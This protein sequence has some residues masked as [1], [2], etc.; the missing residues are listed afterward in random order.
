MNIHISM[1]NLLY[2]PSHIQDSMY[3]G[4]CYPKCGAPGATR[5]SKC[6]YFNYRSNRY[7]SMTRTY[8]YDFVVLVQIVVYGVERLHADSVEVS[9]QPVVQHL[10]HDY[11]VLYQCTHCLAQV[12][13]RCL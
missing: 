5:N 8:G 13:Q 9:V 2:A 4:L 3:H 10:S 7:V 6:I 1:S 11:G 12:T